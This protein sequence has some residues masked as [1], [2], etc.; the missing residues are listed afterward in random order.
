MMYGK[1]LN[2]LSMHANKVKSPALD[3]V[4]EMLEKFAR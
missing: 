2:A 4:L 3:A 1:V